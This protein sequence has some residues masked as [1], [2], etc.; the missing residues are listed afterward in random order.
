[1]ALTCGLVLI[2]SLAVLP[3]GALLAYGLTGTF[4]TLG[5][6]LV[7]LGVCVVAPIDLRRSG[8]LRRREIVIAVVGAALVVFVIIGSVWPAPT[9]PYDRLPWFFALYMGVG[10]L[11]F[12]ALNKARPGRLDG[13]VDDLEG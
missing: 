6:L 8:G 3:L 11:W 7:Y 4:A 13:I 12:A 1:V 5:F 9:A 10:A 2:A